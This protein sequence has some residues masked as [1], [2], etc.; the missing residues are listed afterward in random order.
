MSQSMGHLVLLRHGYSEWNQARRFTGWTDIALND[1]GWAQTDEA[2]KLFAQHGL[3]FDEV[4]TSVLKRTFLMIDPL[5]A[6]AGHPDLPRYTSWRLNERH[7][8]QLQGIG[9]DE[10]FATWGEQTAHGWWRG[11]HQTPPPL[12]WNDPRHPR[13]D[14]LYV[15]FDH[16]T[17]PSSESL[18]DCQQR[19]LPYWQ[20]ILAPRLAEHRNLLVISHGNT[21]RSLIKQL[22]K[23]A[24][25]EIEKVEVPSGVPLVYRFDDG[26]QVSERTWLK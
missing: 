10:I 11:Y 4:H 22:E 2:G 8:G 12:D 21:I 23:I 6:A 5:L 7:Y 16:A 17:L 9:K 15:G 14:P 19:V 13:F 24:D 20:E 1:R 18:F 3:T 25:D 26:F